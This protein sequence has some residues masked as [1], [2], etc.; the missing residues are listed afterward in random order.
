VEK[1]NSAKFQPATD[2]SAAQRQLPKSPFCCSTPEQA[3]FPWPLDP[4]FTELLPHC[5]INR[6]AF[7]VPAT[8]PHRRSRQVQMP[9][10]RFA[11]FYAH[12]KRIMKRIMSQGS[13]VR[14]PTTMTTLLFLLNIDDNIQHPKTNV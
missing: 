7:D 2:R 3:H 9:L 11:V 8:Q 10:F 6:S 4:V 13:S 1:K 14:L 12:Q 5:C